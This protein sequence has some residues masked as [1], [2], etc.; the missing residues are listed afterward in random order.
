[1]PTRLYVKPKTK[2]HYL[3]TDYLR[4][5]GIK[6]ELL[7]DKKGTYFDVTPPPYW[8]KYRRERFQAGLDEL[9]WR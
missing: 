3:A 1:M 8:S 7:T 5:Y 2:A 6:P 9:D 4:L